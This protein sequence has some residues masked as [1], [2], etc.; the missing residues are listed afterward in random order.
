[1]K[2]MDT[3][4]AATPANELPGAGAS[5]AGA[6][7]LPAML[8]AIVGLA[9]Y[10]SLADPYLLRLATEV[11]LIGTAVMCL[12]LV[13]G[14]GG[15]VSLGHGALFG[16]A[17][18][19]GALLA[20]QAGAHLPLVLAAGIVTG[21]LLALILALVSLRSSGLFFLVVTLVAGQLLWEVVFHWRE[22]TGG[23]DGLR[24]FATT[25]AGRPWWTQPLWLYAWAA[26]WAG[27]GYLSL[28]RYLRQPAGIALQ[29]LRDQPLRLRALGYSTGRIRVQA[30][31]ISGVFAGGAGA[32]YPF[33]NVY[34][35]PESVHW[36]FSAALLIMGVIGGIKTL[37]G[38]YAGAAIYL[39]VRTYLSS[40][41]DRWQL[42]IGLL[43]VATVLFMPAG[44]AQGL[45]R[46]RR[47]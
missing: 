12:N 27:I 8:L 3:P 31:V 18:Y 35:S 43:F 9:V 25:A 28:R 23:A 32:L 37:H 30:L 20:Q 46:G 4:G 24:G 42:L 1:M 2:K 13:T 45:R 6:K 7:G 47:R 38:A 14:Q 41:T 34:V 33:I 15:L 17:A 36:S 10:G 39:L 16:G 11:L 19:A 40:Y 26:A 22:V 21:G 44:I 29:A 5:A